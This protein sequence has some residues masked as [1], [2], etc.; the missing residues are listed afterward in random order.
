MR[1][2]CLKGYSPRYNAVMDLVVGGGENM[3]LQVI[4]H[5]PSKKVRLL[6]AILVLSAL[7]MACG[8]A[9]DAAS[10]PGQKK[11]TTKD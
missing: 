6:A 2:Q 7:G 10:E 5:L 3:E 1:L 9:A 11:P 8:Q 4:K